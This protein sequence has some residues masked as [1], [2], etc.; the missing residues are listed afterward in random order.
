MMLVIAQS[1]LWPMFQVQCIWSIVSGPYHEYVPAQT[2]CFVLASIL[3]GVALAFLRPGIVRTFAPMRLASLCGIVGLA[4]ALLE[5]LLASTVGTSASAVDVVAVAEGLCFGALFLCWMEHVRRLAR[6]WGIA[7]V[8]TALIASAMLST[9]IE[10]LALIYAP[11]MRALHLCAYALPLAGMMLTRHDVT[12]SATSSGH[13]GMAVAS[14]SSSI[15][16]SDRALIPY[17][18]IQLFLLGCV[19]HLP[20][21]N[22]M[23]AHSTSPAVSLAAS[24]LAIATLGLLALY[25]SRRLRQ[26][27]RTGQN[28]LTAA[29][30]TVSVIVIA[31]V[32]CL[33]L[34]ISVGG[35]AQIVLERL[36]YRTT[37]VAALVTILVITSQEMSEGY[38]AFAIACL[39][40]SMMAKVVLSLA[41]TLSRFVFG[42]ITYGLLLAC[43]YATVFLMTALLIRLCVRGVAR[44]AAAS[45]ELSVT[46]RDKKRACQSIARRFDLSGREEDVLYYLSQGFSAQKICETLALSAGT[47]NSY[48]SSLYRKL[49][50]HSK[51]AVIDLVNE[52][53]RSLGN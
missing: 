28:S 41:Q 9:A 47:V 19:T 8:S 16:S 46:A 21:V 30:V 26:D 4:S 17:I 50:T 18:G 51:Q 24:L 32:F 3:A 49:G 40:P 13:D 45:P 52:E 31:I 33:M 27:E 37:R 5:A 6:R 39:I 10:P 42:G 44:R 48:S 20:Y 7:C 25:V 34:A 11:L 14:A 22:G 29:T 2:V 15:A 23:E 1:S 53:E 43:M 36:V 35:V 12:T 38:R